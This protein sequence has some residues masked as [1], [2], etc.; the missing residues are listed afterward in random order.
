MVV[1]FKT[2]STLI[3]FAFYSYRKARMQIILS[4]WIQ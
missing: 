3:I 2:I 1:L 4:I